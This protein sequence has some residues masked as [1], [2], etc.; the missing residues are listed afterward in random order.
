MAKLRELIDNAKSK[1]K[2]AWTRVKKW[3]YSLLVAI[4]LIV[5]PLVLANDVNLS[6]VNATQW[7]DGTALVI[8]D[9][10]ET[11]I[12]KQ[13]FPLD[14]T[15]MADPRAYAELTRVAPTVNTYIDANQANGIHCYVATHIATNGK[16]S[17]YSNESC[18]TLD[19][20]IPGNPTGM[21]AQ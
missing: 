11:V 1:A 3:V 6:W 10:Q 17:G 14:G 8:E 9:L 19:V 13:S 4:G 7:E 15:G 2:R 12:Y 21:M 18:K 20:R 5:P 16:E